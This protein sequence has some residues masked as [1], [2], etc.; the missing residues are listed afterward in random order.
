MKRYV[1]YFETS[2]NNNLKKHINYAADVGH[3]FGW[4]A[5]LEGVV[6]Y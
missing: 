5:S 4:V 1:Y 2:T 3:R 6:R